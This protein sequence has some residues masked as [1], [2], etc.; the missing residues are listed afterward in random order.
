MRPSWLVLLLVLALL[1]PGARPRLIGAAMSSS[2]PGSS[3][4]SSSQNN[5]ET[6]SEEEEHRENACSSRYVLSL[7]A[8][9]SL[10][11]RPIPQFKRFARSVPPAAPITLL[12][13]NGFGG[14]IIC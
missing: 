7:G 10:D 4:S 11:K 5:S 12:S 9:R 1:L 8:D 14:H 3:S 2:F 6:E 13:E